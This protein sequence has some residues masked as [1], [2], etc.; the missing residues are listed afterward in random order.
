MS[1]PRRL[2]LI[3]IPLAGQ[4]ALLIW[5][6]Q[7]E[8]LVV[9]RLS[10]VIALLVAATGLIPAMVRASAAALVAGIA[11]ILLAGMIAAPADLTM[12][13][14][15]NIPGIIGLPGGILLRLINTALLGPL[16]L[17]F[18]TIFPS[19]HPA[20]RLVAIASGA[21]LLALGAALL[22]PQPWGQIAGLISIG[23]SVG[24]IGL[25]VARLLGQIR[26]QPRSPAS[27]QA[28][29]ILLMTLFAELPMLLRPIL[30]G[31]FGVLLPYEATL[32][33]QPILPLG[34]IY[35]IT[36]HDLFGID[37]TLRRALLYTMLSLGVLT[38]YLALTVVLTGVLALA[39]PA[40]RGFA[41]SIALIASAAAFGP[42]R[43]QTQR[44]IDH[45][46]YPERVA[47]QQ[48]IAAAEARLSLVIDHSQLHVLLT[49]DLPAQIGAAWATLRLAPAPE[50]ADHPLNDQVISLG[51]RVGDQALGRYWLGPR[52]SGLPYTTEEQHALQRVAERAALAYAY[53]AAAERV[54]AATEQRQQLAR[55]LHDSVTQTLFS[56]NLGARAIRNLIQHDPQAARTALLEQEQ[57]AQQALAEMR[58][59]LIQLRSDHE[60]APSA[61]VRDLA[62]LLREHADTLRRRGEL[63]VQYHGPPTLLLPHM[64]SDQLALIAREALHNAAKHS[65][66]D[67]ADLQLSAAASVIELTV[68]DT[69]L[70]F[71]PA[72]L[73]TG[74]GLRGMHERAAQ[75]GATLAITSA[76]HQ[77]TMVRVIWPI[78]VEKQPDSPTGGGS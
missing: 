4:I 1:H 6:V 64:A 16:L 72:D 11:S 27:G 55:D 52:Q 45:W 28:R 12:I 25:T 63:M 48:A 5:L 30:I 73:T 18:S 13:T 47:F 65:H 66:A 10:L 62:L 20:N 59:L 7:S 78:P 54:A 74:H 38:L 57:A 70:G 21:V 14:P 8:R 32:I 34:M 60:P 40:A 67:Q 15:L 33:T 36:R 69:G 42:L 75:I 3:I 51:L 49:T 43:Q 41:A 23:G 46:L 22:L 53:A 37:A 29:I 56:L 44:L 9:D 76:R 61:G 26:A 39:L 31:W 68:R 19:A 77:G 17:F 58:S 71:D 2:A 24:L 35:A 50:V